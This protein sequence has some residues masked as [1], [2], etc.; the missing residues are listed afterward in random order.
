MTDSGRLLVCATPIGNLGDVTLRVLDA[1]REA[2]V[3]AAEDT[4]VTSR[5]LGRYDIA[6]PVVRYDAHTAASRAGQLVARMLGGEVVALVSDAGT[7]GLSDPGEELVAAAIEAGVEVDVL[8][9]ASSVLTALVISGAPTMPFYFGGFLPRK[10]GERRRLLESLGEL[11]AT[12]VFFESPRRT[13]ASLADVSAV[14]PTRFV[15]VTREL[16]KIHQ[17]VIRGVSGEVAEVLSARDLKGEVA[18]VIGPPD[19]NAP[20]TVDEVAVREA[21]DALVSAGATR[22]D[23]IRLVARETGLPRN[24]VYRIA[25]GGADRGVTPP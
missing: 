25:H 13:A 5:L 22:S 12:L 3:I 23:A 9:G 1:L 15:A 19:R 17:E 6:T 18:I 7:P 24:E 16:T 8:P 2:D 4:R 14:M 11:A 10:S 21:L 20:R